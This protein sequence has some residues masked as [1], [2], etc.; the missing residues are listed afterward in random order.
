MY[1]SHDHFKFLTDQYQLVLCLPKEKSHHWYQFWNESKQ[2]QIHKFDIKK[3]C[4]TCDSYHSV[5]GAQMGCV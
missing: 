4:F 5:K 2:V 1:Q 3:S